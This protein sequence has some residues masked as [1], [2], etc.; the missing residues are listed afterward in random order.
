[1]ENI[2]PSQTVLEKFRENPRKAWTNKELC[3]AIKNINERKM[4][5][6]TQALAASGKIVVAT[7]RDG[8]SN[9]YRLPLS[10]LYEYE[11]AYNEGFLE[12]LKISN[13]DAFNEGKKS[14]ARFLAKK[15]NL[16]IDFNV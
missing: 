12:G 11:K 10:A 2:D 9:V 5:R 1:M 15:L 3:E 4:R 16:E 14:V 8:S 13:L 7:K 6:T